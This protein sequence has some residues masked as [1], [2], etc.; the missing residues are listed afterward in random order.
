M[1]VLAYVRYKSV[2]RQIDEDTYSPSPVL[3]VL[4]A[5][6]VLVIGV[7]LLLYLVHSM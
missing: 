4:L 7:F 1:G 6:S 5:L 2:Q 3:S